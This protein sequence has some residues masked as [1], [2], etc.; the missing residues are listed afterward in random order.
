MPLSYSVFAL[1]LA[2]SVLYWLLGFASDFVGFIYYLV[3][4]LSVRVSGLTLREERR[5]RVFENW[6]SRKTVEQQVTGEARQLSIEK[7]HDL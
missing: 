5:L 6:A 4:V 7:L 3:V 1:C 2:G